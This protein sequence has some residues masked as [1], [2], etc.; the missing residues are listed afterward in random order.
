ME[1]T[2]E[3]LNRMKSK[4]NGFQKMLA[5]LYEKENNLH[6]IKLYDL[7]EEDFNKFRR[8]IKR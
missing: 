6:R 7:W 1:V 4:G 2:T 8:E 5:S 3:I